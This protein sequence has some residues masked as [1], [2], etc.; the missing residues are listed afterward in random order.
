MNINELH[1]LFLQSKGVS[2][3]TRK[4]KKGTIFFALKGDNFN[5]NR[6]A[7]Q[8]IEKGAAF[9]A[10]DEVFDSHERIIQVDNVLKTLQQL[11][12]FHRNYL[13]IPIIAVTGSNGKTTTKELLN[14]VLSKKFNTK[15]TKGNLNNHIGVPLT[16]L[17]MDR[18]TEV[19]I[20]E[21]GANHLGEIAG[22]CEIALPNYGYITN[23]GKAH[24]EGFGGVEGVIKGKSELY[25]FL[26][27]NKKIIFV[28]TEDVIQVEQSK[29]AANYRIGEEKNADCHV[30]FLKADPFVELQFENLVVKTQLMGSYNSKN[31]A[32]AIGIGTFFKVPAQEIKAAIENYLPANNRSQIIEKNGNKIVL[33]AYNANPTSMLAALESFDS[34]PGGNKVLLLGDMFELGKNSLTEHQTI[35]EKIETLEFDR[36]YLC[37]KNFCQTKTSSE[38]TEQFEDFEMLKKAIETTRFSNA[39]ILVKGSRGM[40]LER[41]VEYL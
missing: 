10:V 14:A 25:G 33:D 21:M 36:V 24:L 22:L 6:F 38:K 30:K 5:G 2:T 27:A 32:A 1:E 23:F 12:K 4:I 19:G 17:S 15:V 37:G 34:F 3:D 8:A 26:K 29:G 18:T 40:A 16:L 35:V 13:K 28:K 31:C 7:L 11:A 20:V 9:V 41:I 39:H